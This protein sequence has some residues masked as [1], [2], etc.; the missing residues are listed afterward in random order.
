[1]PTDEAEIIARA[2]RGDSAAR[3]ALV[4]LHQALV[5]S[6]ARHVL[7]H[8]EEVHDVFQSVFLRLFKHLSGIDPERGA[9]GWLRRTTVNACFDRIKA[10][11]KRA[12]LKNE[13][14]EGA[15]SNTPVEVAQRREAHDA[16]RQALQELSPQHRATVVLHYMEGLKYTEIAEALDVS[17]ETVRSRLKRARAELRKR[18]R[19]YH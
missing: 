14:D 15:T 18:L 10:R 7:G 1:M 4:D 19:E 3:S 16:V 9:A 17:V 12:G 11:R 2:C 6:V 8:D 5:Y 13:G